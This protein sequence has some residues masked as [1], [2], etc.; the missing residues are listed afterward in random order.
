MDKSPIRVLVVEDCEPWRRYFSM[1]PQKQPEL[2]VIGEV[3]DGLEA[4]QKAQE[5][6]PDLILLDIGLPSLNG[7]EVARRIRKVSPASRILFVSENRS[8]DIAEE[9][10]STGASGYVVKSDAASEL[11]RAVNAALEGKRF[12]S[13]SLSQQ[14]VAKSNAGA[15]G[16]TQE[17]ENNPYMR[18]GRSALLSEFLA[19]IIK[20]TSADFG[21]I[22]LFDSTNRVLRIVAYHGFGS[23]FLDYFNTVSDSKECVC[24]VAMSGRSRI[25]V[26]DV[27]TDP[28]FSDESRG[29]LLRAKVRSV[30]STP[31]ID[32]L[33][34]FVGMVSTHF[35]L[36]GSP[37]PDLLGYVD[38][39]VASFLAKLEA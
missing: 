25:L 37:M 6:Q 17:I 10:L 31:L 24:G 14:V 7:L 4:V 20:A 8:A 21:N 35:T 39:L 12:V 5:L 15:S 11:P 29:V 23:E 27:A 32:P 19:S 34:K 2:Q 3:S 28:V 36:P 1:T 16:S 13:V 9:A 22:Q 26:T 33:G 38:N 30:Q 18:F